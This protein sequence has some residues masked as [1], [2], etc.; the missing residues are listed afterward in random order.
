MNR[1]QIRRRLVGTTVLLS[2]AVIFVPMLLD[3]RV[4]DERL[5]VVIPARADLD[6]DAGLA[7]RAA[8]PLAAPA[9]ADL[10]SV[11]ASDI[12]PN[13]LPATAAGN[14][15][16]TAPAEL[17]SWV[18]QVG[19]YARSDNADGVAARLRKAGFDTV[20]DRV[21][22]DGQALY[23]VQVGP[24]TDPDRA[25]QVQARIQNRLQLDGTVLLRQPG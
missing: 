21:D 18:V 13:S 9:A 2:L 19:S 1:T 14:A 25:R 17:R 4:A 6:F 15:S 23:R 22:L 11:A 20:V 7:A 5:G 8:Q 24:E 10:P 16:S 3:S 12:D